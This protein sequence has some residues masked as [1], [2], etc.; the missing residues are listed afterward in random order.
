M[1]AGAIESMSGLFDGSGS[2]GMSPIIGGQN[3]FM[4]YPGTPSG[5]SGAVPAPPATGSVAAPSV[6][7]MP[8]IGVQ[9][10]N[11]SAPSVGGS[12]GGPGYGIV[13]SQPSLPGST[14]IP[15][16]GAGPG[17]GGTVPGT[18][19][20]KL[21]PTYDPQFTQQIYSMLSQM[22]GQGVQ[23]FN[24]AT[25]L[26]GGGSTQPG[27]LT[28][29]LNSTLSQIQQFLSGGG[30]NIPGA[31]SLAS[32]ANTGAPIDQT[33]AWQAMINSEQQNI[34]QNQAD[35]REQFA[36]GG[37][38][39]GSEFGNAMSNYM[40]GVTSNQNAQLTQAQTQAMQQAVQ[41]QLIA[42]QGL[43]NEA[44]SFGSGLQNLDQQ[45]IQ[46]LLQE[47]ERTSP[48]NNPLIPMMM[49]YGLASPQVV[50][51]PTASQTFGQIASGI[52]SLISGGGYSSSSGPSGSSSSMTF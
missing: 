23:P 5:S 14:P 31:S 8:R 6:I 36:F 7:S 40:Q 49:Q 38:L 3:Q 52:G 42:G 15:Y 9:G 48:Q 4:S 1:A 35:L 16:K 24:L 41:N 25:A 19:Y 50:N 22:L 44:Q 28:A 45:A 32:I 47:F 26:P 30:S 27:Q 17:A 11:P 20:D 37:A 51:T 39:G 21:A 10:N 12:S 33:P 18:N 13:P 46:N 29:P 34:A 2:G 43:Q